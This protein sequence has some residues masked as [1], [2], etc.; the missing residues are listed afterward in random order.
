MVSTGCGL[1]NLWRRQFAVGVWGSRE[2]TGLNIWTRSH[3]QFRTC[4]KGCLGSD[5]SSFPPLLC[6]CLKTDAIRKAFWLYLSHESF[7]HFHQ[8]LVLLGI[9][10]P[11]ENRDY[12]PWDRRALG[13]PFSVSR[14]VGCYLFR[15]VGFKIKLFEQMLSLKVWKISTLEFP[16]FFFGHFISLL[17]QSL[18]LFFVLGQ[19]FSKCYLN[20][21]PCLLKMQTSGPSVYWISISEKVLRTLCI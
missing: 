13:Q 9:S 4:W 11:C 7:T 18:T 5:A 12:Q 14:G 21:P 15:I 17:F 19:C 8:N 10:W 2:K 6:L 20:P 16:A 1:M 3:E